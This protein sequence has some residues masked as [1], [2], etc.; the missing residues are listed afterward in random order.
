MQELDAE[1]Q[2]VIDLAD[3]LNEPDIDFNGPT[4]TDIETEA[5]GEASLEPAASSA[6]NDAFSDLESEFPDFFEG[7]DEGQEDDGDAAA[8]DKK[9]SED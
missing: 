6:E 8:T 2:Q 3:Q 4:L 1:K 5:L 7:T 9:N